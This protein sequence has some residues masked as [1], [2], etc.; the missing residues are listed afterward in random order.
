VA[1]L[2]FAGGWAT[3]GSLVDGRYTVTIHSSLVHDHQ[4]GAALDG[5]GD[6][7]VGG[8]RVDQ[9]FRLFGDVNGD[10]KVDHTDVAAFLQAYHSK[11]GM[12]AYAWYS[13][14]NNDGWV[15]ATD[16]YQF[17][18]HYGHRLTPAGVLS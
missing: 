1:T 10:A 16:Y 11:K 5:D 13:D 15:D 8:D 2:T 6:G 18:A 9:F 4:L 17:L 12:A 14:V 3:G 7:L